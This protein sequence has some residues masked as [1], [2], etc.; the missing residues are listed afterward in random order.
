MHIEN[1][2]NAHSL[3]TMRQK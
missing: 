3:H 2:H 1:L